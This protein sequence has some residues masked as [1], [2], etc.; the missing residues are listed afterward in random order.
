MSA[1]EIDGTTRLNGLGNIT[2]SLWVGGEEESAKNDLQFLGYVAE[3]R[4]WVVFIHDGD[5]GG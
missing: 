2:G 4:S 5:R 3:K 1:C